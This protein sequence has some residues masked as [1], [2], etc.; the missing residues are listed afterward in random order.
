MKLST[1]LGN[2]ERRLA[3]RNCQCEMGTTNQAGESCGQLAV[4]GLAD[5]RDPVSV[6]CP[7][8]GKDRLVIKVYGGLYTED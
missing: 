2:L 1:R 4:G 3:P 6:R 7:C 5:D 8:C